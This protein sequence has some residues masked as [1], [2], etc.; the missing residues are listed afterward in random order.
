VEKAQGRSYQK[1]F[2]TKKQTN[3]KTAKLVD[4]EKELGKKEE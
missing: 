3:H 1:M 4:E 2:G